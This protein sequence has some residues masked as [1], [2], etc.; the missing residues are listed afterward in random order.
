MRSVHVKN[1]ACTQSCRHDFNMRNCCE[2]CEN[3]RPGAEFGD[4]YRVVEVPFDVRWVHLCIGHARIAENSGV[5]SFEQLRE[6]YGSG[7]RSFIPRRGR[8]TSSVN[9]KRRSPGRRASDA[10]LG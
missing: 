8:G 5:T 9:E 7:R 4:G 10:C 2:V 1:L 3:F 6:L